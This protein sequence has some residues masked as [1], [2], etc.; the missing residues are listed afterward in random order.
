MQNAEIQGM[1]ELTLTEVD[2]VAGGSIGG[3]V[4]AGLLIGT[5]VIGAYIW[6]DSTR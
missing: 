4:L 2:Q 6:Y 3:A 5:L 1:Q